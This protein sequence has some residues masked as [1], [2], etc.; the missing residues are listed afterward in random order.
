MSG[1]AAAAVAAVAAAAA[2]SAA[3]TAAHFQ[4]QSSSPRPGAA[5][6][7]PLRRPRPPLPP[8]RPE[9]AAAGRLSPPGHGPLRAGAQAGGACGRAPGAGSVGASFQCQS[10]HHDH[11]CHDDSDKHG[12]LIARVTAP[13]GPDR[14]CKA[15]YDL[16]SEVTKHHFQHSHRPAQ[17]Q[18]EEPQSPHWGVMST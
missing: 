14:C 6:L 5:E 2:A 15:F 11:I 13:R 7:G 3:A 8:P 4:P 1:S 17:I 10:I 18:K 9:P 12:S 16:T